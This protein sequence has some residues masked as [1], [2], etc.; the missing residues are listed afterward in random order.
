MKL[1][2]SRCY[3]GGQQHRFEARY[4]TGRGSAPLVDAATLE[5]LAFFADSAHK[6]EVILTAGGATRQYQGD[7]C[8]W[9]GKIVNQPGV[10]A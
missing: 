2:P 4:S 6:A 10:K 1:F 9:C 3:N 8:V 5:S 7:V